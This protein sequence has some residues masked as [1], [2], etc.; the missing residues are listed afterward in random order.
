MLLSFIQLLILLLLAVA[1]L[2][3]AVACIPKAIVK[4]APKDIQEKV[5]ARPDYPKW[6][7]ILGIILLIIIAI[8]ILSVFVW[9]GYDAVQNDWEFGMIFVRFLIL[10]EGYKIFD[11]IC[12]DYILLTKLNIFQTFFPETV[13]CKGYE[14]FGFNLKSQ[15][16]KIFVFAAIAFVISM[17]LA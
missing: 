17:I 2:A 6:R 7:T 13:G 4:T 10:L 14:K 3:A 16:V 5:L 9:A 11:M 12:F 8:G 15:I 1:F